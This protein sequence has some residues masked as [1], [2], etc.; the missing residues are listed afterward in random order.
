[1]KNK[2]LLSGTLLVFALS[3]LLTSAESSTNASTTKPRIE[4]PEW[5]KQRNEEA[6]AEFEAR[7]KEIEQRREDLKDEMESKRADFKAENKQNKEA[8]KNEIET[9]KEDL[10]NKIEE[11]KEGAL[12]KI[13]ERLVKFNQNIKERFDAAIERLE[14]LAGRIDSRIA[15]METENKDVKT[16]KDLMVVAKLKIETAKTSIAGIDLEAGVIA[17]STATSTSAFKAD[18]EKLKNQVEKAKNDIRSA[19]SSLIDVVNSLKPGQATTTTIY[20]G[21]TC[22][23]LI[24]PTMW[25]VPTTCCNC[26]RFKVTK[27][28]NRMYF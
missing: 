13:Q 5:F 1:M 10:K 8:L 6:K 28:R 12:G 11:R 3:P 21:C 15:K 24:F 14:Q 25:Y 23:K 16:A 19:H 26:L 27:V 20:L 2:L 7:K 9:R 17:S 4:S 22:R 18:F